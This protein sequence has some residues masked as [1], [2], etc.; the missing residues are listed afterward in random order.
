M[1]SRDEISCVKRAAAARRWGAADQLFQLPA[2]R[3][4]VTKAD[5]D[6]PGTGPV[7]SMTASYLQCDTEMPRVRGHNEGPIYCLLTTSCTELSNTSFRN[8]PMRIAL[9]V[10]QTDEVRQ[11]CTLFAHFHGN[12]AA[13]FTNCHR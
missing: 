2:D 9:R 13:V 5:R 3:G 4:R 11:A 12:L 1:I 6:L 7:R 8:F 10:V